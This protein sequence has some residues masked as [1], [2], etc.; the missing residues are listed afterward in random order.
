MTRFEMT[1]AVQ[2]VLRQ[3]D[4]PLTLVSIR[5]VPFAW[6][7]RLEDVDGIER[8]MTVHQGSA[9]VVSR[10]LPF[11]LTGDGGAIMAF[12]A[13]LRSFTIGR[14]DF[15]ACPV[16]RGHRHDVVEIIPCIRRPT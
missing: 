13:S 6:E 14:K 8:V 3:T 11:C 1:T 2:S 5:A 7:L 9:E 16:R 10:L 12:A 15:A 4:F